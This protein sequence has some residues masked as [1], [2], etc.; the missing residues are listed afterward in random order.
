MASCGKT[1][2]SP[3]A[4]NI[5]LQVV[6]AGPDILPVNLY[7]NFTLQNTTPYA[8]PNASGYITPTT[9]DTPIQIR[10]AETSGGTFFNLDYVLKPNTRYTLFVT[11][12]RVDQNTST[13]IFTVDTAAVPTVGRGKVRF[14]NAS[15]R[16]PGLDI[17]A[18]GTLAFSNQAFRAVAPFIELPAGIYDFKIFNAGTNTNVINDFPNITIQD[19]R[20]YTLYTY[21]IIGRTDT[22]AFASSI[23]VNR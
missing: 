9:I 7:I 23:L 17:Y 18:N 20:L 11:G 13:P 6:N 19:G 22:S 3:A 14:V 1:A 10:T 2:V 12:L 15:P 8:Y 21:G 4:S 5:Q 16:S